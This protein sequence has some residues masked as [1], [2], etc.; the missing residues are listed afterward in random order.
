MTKPTVTAP[1]QTDVRTFAQKKNTTV[2]QSL[3]TGSVAGAVE[4]GVNHPLWTIKIRMQCGDPFTLNPRLLYR[5]IVP[6]AASMIPITG[7]QVGFDRCLLRMLYKDGAELTD[8]QCISSAFVAGVGSAPASCITEM[9]MTHQK[10]TGES[11]YTAGKYVVSNSG[12]RGLF[13]GLPATMMREGIFTPFF[14]AVTPILKG[15]VLPYVPNNGVALLVAGIGSGLGATILSQA[16]DTLKTIQQG[17][18]HPQQVSL[19]RVVREI[20]VKD[21]LYGFFRGG[22]PRGARVVSAVTVMGLVT[23]KMEALFLKTDVAIGSTS[24]KK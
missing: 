19:G 17:A 21:G 20:Y 10:K 2:I 13:T 22:I 24:V 15:K 7:I 16:A 1:L 23:D 9:V 14:L 18:A 5:G 12:W 11:F 3:I 6:N 4:V 8:F